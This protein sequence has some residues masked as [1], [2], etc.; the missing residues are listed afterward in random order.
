MIET[1]QRILDT[2]ERLIAE[3]GCAATSLRHIIAEA[4]VNL[5]AIHYHFGSKEELLDE[6]ILRKAAP[7]NQERLARLDR[8]EQEAGDRP[9]SVKAVLA[10]FLRPTAE[11]ADRDP[12]FIAFMGRIIAEG[13]LPSVVERHFQ[14]AAGRILGALRRAVPALPETE[15]VWRTQFLF[16]AMA[17]TMCG[18]NLPHQ[19]VRRGDFRE[20]VERLITFVTAGFEAPATEIAKSGEI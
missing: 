3:Q 7:M 2:A 20:R 18:L 13:L 19:E 9:P 10:A 5:A 4:G 17:H 12:S 11:M 16:G 1:K 14:P 8:A 6:V 15:F